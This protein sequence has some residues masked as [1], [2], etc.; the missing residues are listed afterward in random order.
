MHDDQGLPIQKLFEVEL[1]RSWLVPTSASCSKDAM[2]I[3]LSDGI[4]AFVGIKD[5]S[6]KSW[7]WHG[8]QSFCEGASVAAVTLSPDG[9]LLAARVSASK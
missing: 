3:A 9:K 5:A 1:P 4:R 7:L 6:N 8:P 2:Q